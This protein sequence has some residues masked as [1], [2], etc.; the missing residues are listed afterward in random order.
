[1]KVYRSEVLLAILL[2]ATPGAYSF[3]VSDSFG[4]KINQDSRFVESL[5]IK[6]DPKPLKTVIYNAT[7][8]MPKEVY[9]V[10]FI[11]IAKTGATIWMRDDPPFYETLFTITSEKGQG[12]EFLL[13]VMHG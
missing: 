1:M 8:R 4:P 12:F 11:D 5:H 10:S 13:Q 2:L 9:A 7:I 3:D 6:R